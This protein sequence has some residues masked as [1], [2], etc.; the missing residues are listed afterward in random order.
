MP[1]GATR[2]DRLGAATAPQRRGRFTGPSSVLRSLLSSSGLLV[3]R[4]AGRDAWLL[5]ACTPLV[6][7]SALLA[8]AGPRSVLNTVDGG[9]RDTVEAAGL[10]SVVDIRAA[11]G[12]STASSSAVPMTPTKDFL[13]LAAT[14]QAQLPPVLASVH[15]ST[16][17]SLVTAPARLLMRNDTPETTLDDDGEVQLQIARLSADETDTVEI[18]KGRLPAAQGTRSDASVEVILSQAVADAISVDVGDR[19]TVLAPWGP[20]P[21]GTQLGA[22]LQVVGIVA[23]VAQDAPLWEAIP[24]TWLPVHQD[25]RSDRAAY[26]RGTLLAA[27]DGMAA[28]GSVLG[29]PGTGIIRLRVD[30]AAFTTRVAAEV[31]AELDALR[32]N[33][34]VLAGDTRTPLSLRT[35]LGD[36][37]RA[38][39]PQARAAL[40]QMSVVIAGV[41]GVAAVVMVLLSR[42]LVIRRSAVIALERARG[43]SVPAIALRLAAE[44]VP[45]AALGGAA[46]IAAAAW[47]VPGALNDLLPVGVVVTVAV[48]AAPVQGAWL[49]RRAWTGRREPANRQDRA[50]LAKRRTARRLVLESGALVLALAAAFA[51]RT[52]GLLQ[53]TTEG[54]DPFLAAAPLLLAIAITVLLLRVYPW[55]I[56]VVGVLGRRTRGVLGLLGAV[57]A[58]R[59]VAV[60]PLLALTLGA[61]VAVAGG[62]LVDTVRTGQ[63]EASWERVGADIRVDAELT[64]D[65]VAAIAEQPGVTAVGSAHVARS[66]SFDAGTGSALVTLVAADRQYAD[67]LAATPF[68]SGTDVAGLA[69]LADT[70][71]VDGKIPIVTGATLAR[72][73]GNSAAMYFG[74]EY[75]RVALAGATDYAPIGFFEGPFVFA[76]LDTLSAR[77]PD[78]LNATSTLVVGPGA[79]QAVAS[80]GVPPESVVS[81]AE[82]LAARRGLALHDGVEQMMIFAVIAS[83]LLCVVALVATVLAGARERGRALSMLHTLG[84]HPR[85][86]WWLALA[87]L[88]PVV[89][90]AVVGGAAAGVAIVVVLAPALG[91][92]V[93][94]GGLGIPDPSISPIVIIGLAATAVGLLVLAAGVEV[95]AHRRDRL[96]DVLRVGETA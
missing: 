38:Y 31:A 82:W 32:V 90:A 77:M 86:G 56:R 40:A 48:L 19:L 29:A 21:V 72:R 63:V 59:A 55:P 20:V 84:M 62:L 28:L 81:R 78:G 7:L 25:A 4:R 30:P 1:A 8:V 83:G 94:A 95:L 34:S 23:P 45:I 14:V 61:A 58:Q 18:V 11:V 53:V 27:D 71:A 92:D 37:L 39:P 15:E 43:A 91:L 68:T 5:L 12:D 76:D 74:P 88:T 42:L 54:T 3:R 80:V 6:A 85:L 46:G 73:V 65:Q 64:R 87:E 41:V 51:L 16:T 57:R 49:A 13:A 9:A 47:V 96:S 33:T 79:A 52:R 93:L 89:V 70:P 75:V 24:E 22:N 44:W 35:E 36:A 66:V 50:Q 26:T 17:V 60:L 69:A 10:R 67:L 2:P